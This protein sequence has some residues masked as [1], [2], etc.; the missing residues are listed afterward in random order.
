MED[1][2]AKLESM[3]PGRV[4]LAY[5]Q[6]SEPFLA[7]VLEE[8]V[9]GNPDLIQVLP[10]FLSS[11]GHVQRDVN[12]LIQ[13]AEQKHAARIELL[14]TIG[15]TSEFHELLFSLAACHLQNTQ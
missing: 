12:P 13:Q 2:L 7:D 11:G 1:L 15:E 8:V 4:H 3:H 14:P 9:S 5:L 10:V 6:F